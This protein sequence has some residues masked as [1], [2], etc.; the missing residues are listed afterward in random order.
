MEG[1]GSQGKLTS[2]SHMPALNVMIGV[3]DIVAKW[4]GRRNFGDE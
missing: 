1:H 2:T 4:A 3:I